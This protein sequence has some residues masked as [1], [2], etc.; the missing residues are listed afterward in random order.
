MCFQRARASSMGGV[1]PEGVGCGLVGPGDGGMMVLALLLLEKAVVVLGVEI[2][3]REGRGVVPLGGNGGVGLR[4]D[5]LFCRVGKR[6]PGGD[7][8]GCGAVFGVGEPRGML[9]LS[10]GVGEAVA[11]LVSSEVSEMRMEGFSTAV[12]EELLR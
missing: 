4:V 3:G 9:K 1:I 2:R 6:E 10:E 12:S 5:W 7:G 8:G 11:E